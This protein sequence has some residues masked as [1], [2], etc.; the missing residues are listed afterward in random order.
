M[1]IIIIIIEISTKF[2]GEEVNGFGS[3]L[4]DWCIPVI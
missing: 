1:M 2:K 4:K 3:N